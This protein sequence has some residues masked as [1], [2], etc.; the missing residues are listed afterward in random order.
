MD[1]GVSLVRPVLVCPVNTPQPGGGQNRRVRHLAT[2]PAGP[3]TA[4]ARCAGA[5][6]GGRVHGGTQLRRRRRQPRRR[7][8]FTGL[9]RQGVVGKGRRATAQSGEGG[10]RLCGALLI[11]TLAFSFCLV[12]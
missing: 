7:L 10:Q 5:I 2:P 12:W 6:G 11:S 4:I 3:A 9:L 1:G 8:R